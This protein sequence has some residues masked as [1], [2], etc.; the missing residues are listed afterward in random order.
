[1]KRYRIITMARCLLVISE[2]FVYELV[3]NYTK[4]KHI[5]LKHY[6]IQLLDTH[7]HTPHT[8]THTHTSHTH[9]LLS[10]MLPPSIVPLSC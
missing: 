9:T 1:M 2:R 6:P 5:P 10:I 3:N 8:H 7:I 4:S